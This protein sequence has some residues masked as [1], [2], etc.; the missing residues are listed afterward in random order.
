MRIVTRHLVHRIWTEDLALVL[1]NKTDVQDVLKKLEKLSLK[2][3]QVV[4]A[5]TNALV[6]ESEPPNLS[7]VQ[8]AHT[9]NIL[10]KPTAIETRV[11]RNRQARAFWED[12]SMTSHSL[13]QWSTASV[14]GSNRPTQTPRITTRRAIRVVVNG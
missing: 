3:N 4:D 8:I 14:H 1:V 7:H 2:E 13:I 9:I 5:D 6:R 11:Q 12:P 10:R